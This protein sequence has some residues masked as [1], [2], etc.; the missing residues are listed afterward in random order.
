[1]IF[2]PCVVVQYQCR[3]KAFELKK[4]RNQVVYEFLGSQPPTATYPL[5]FFC[6]FIFFA[7]ACWMCP[8]FFNLLCNQKHF[9]LKQISSMLTMVMPGTLSASNPHLSK[10]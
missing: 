9:F 1:M 4:M 7:L 10:T 8:L 2:V 6:P 5:V 3:K